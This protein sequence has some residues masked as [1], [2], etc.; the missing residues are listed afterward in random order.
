MD[1]SDICILLLKLVCS[2]LL[3]KHTF[4][5]ISSHFLLLHLFTNTVISFSVSYQ[6]YSYTYFLLHVTCNK[7]LCC[8]IFDI[9]FQFL[10]LGICLET[11]IER[12]FFNLCLLWQSKWILGIHLSRHF[13]I[14]F[15]LWIRIFILRS[16]S[17]TSLICLFFMFLCFYHTQR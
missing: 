17:L 1:V 5:S 3:A 6:W 8:E 15:Y 7:F 2:C 14:S 13:F 9:Y 10:S 11:F 4:P 12:T 16:F